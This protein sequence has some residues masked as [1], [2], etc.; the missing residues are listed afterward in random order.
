TRGAASPLPELPAEARPRGLPRPHQGARPAPLAPKNT[1][2]GSSSEPEATRTGSSS[3]S[4]QAE[5][6]TIDEYRDRAPGAGLR[7]DR[8]A[9]DQLRN[10]PSREAGGR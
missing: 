7:P 8:D 1:E 5:W 10:R 2:G 9:G 6:R 4:P 3:R